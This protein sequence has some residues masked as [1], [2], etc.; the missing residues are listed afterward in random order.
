[1]NMDSIKE[2]LPKISVYNDITSKYIEEI[3]LKYG[4]TLNYTHLDAS[5]I[6]HW[7]KTFHVAMSSNGQPKLEK[8]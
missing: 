2:T 4:I 1:M 8:P 5:E 6:G 3:T 7:A